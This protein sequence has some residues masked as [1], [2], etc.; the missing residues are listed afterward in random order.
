MLGVLIFPS[1]LSHVD[2]PTA[3][4]KRDHYRHD[5]N[6]NQYRLTKH[7][8]SSTLVRASILCRIVM[9]RRRNLLILDVKSLIPALAVTAVHVPTK[10]RGSTTEKTKWVE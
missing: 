4:A 9:V 7:Q 6:P 8:S 5:R 2:E 3:A 1:A 10:T